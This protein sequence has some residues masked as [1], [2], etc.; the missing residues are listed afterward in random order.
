MQAPSRIQLITIAAIAIV[1]A[2]GIGVAIRDHLPVGPAGGGGAAVGPPVRGD[3]ARTVLV[4][5]AGEVR[6]PGVY[7]LSTGSR[8]R[9]AIQAAGGATADANLT[10]VN[11]AAPVVDGQHL[12]VPVASASAGVPG[13]GSA[14][15]AAGV[16]SQAD[17]AAPVSINTADVAGLDELP[18]VGPATAQAIVDDRSDNGPFSD[19]DDLQRV[20]GIGPATVERIRDLVTL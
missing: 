20:A 13:A 15:V 7:E 18:G 6:S 17:T 4:D 9:D 12:V 10:A 11:R 5:V 1:I 8:A 16:D 19:V 3:D 2:T 14:D